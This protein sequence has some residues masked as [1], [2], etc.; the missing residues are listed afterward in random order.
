MWAQRTYTDAHASTVH[1]RHAATALLARLQP[2][3]AAPE[4]PRALSTVTRR[5]SRR[6]RVNGPSVLMRLPP[7]AVSGAC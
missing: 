3:R 2:D 1:I 7:A 6:E 4:E 5:E